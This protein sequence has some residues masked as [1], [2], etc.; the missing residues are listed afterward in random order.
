VLLII[1]GLYF[2]TRLAFANIAYVDRQQ[3]VK[4]SLSYSWHL[5]KG[6][7]FWTVFLVLIIEICLI[8]LGTITLMIG[9]LLTSPL[10]ML[11]VVHLYRALTIFHHNQQ[12]ALAE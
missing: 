9:L 10:A 8:M 6:K 3:S 12:K 1:P 11:L 5:V 2:L 7:I 4:K